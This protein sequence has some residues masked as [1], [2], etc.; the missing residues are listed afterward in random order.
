MNLLFAI[1]LKGFNFV[2]TLNGSLIRSTGGANQES[3]IR[4]N[5]DGTVDS[6][7]NAVY[8]QLTAATNWIIPNSGGG[9]AYQVRFTNHSGTVFTTLAATED[10]WIDLSADR[11]WFMSSGINATMTVDFEIRRGTG[12][13]LASANYPIEVVIS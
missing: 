5:S 3:G 2:L 7:K 8:A 13:V 11:E 4:F 10:T 1:L 6:K 12:A 9:G